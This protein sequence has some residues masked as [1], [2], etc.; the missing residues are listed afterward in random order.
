MVVLA[1][2]VVAAALLGRLCYIGRPFD[3]DAAVFIYM[4]KLIGDGGR[5]CHDLIDNKFPTVGLLTGV[6]W[7]AFGRNWWMYVALQTVMS[8]TAAGVLADIARRHFGRT[9]GG[10]DRVLPTL[11][12]AL[13]YLN[14]SPVVFGGFQLET[15]QLFFAVL[16]AH[17]AMQALHR[18][19][20]ADAFVVGLCAGCGAMAK[21]TALAVGAAF[22]LVT[23][24]ARWREWRRVSLHGVASL[25]GLAVPAL[26][27][28][29]YLLA[30]DTLRD[31]PG[32]SRQLSTYASNSV[33]AAE[34][35]IKPAIVAGLLGFPMIVYAWMTRPRLAPSA[36]TRGEG[37]ADLSRVA[38]WFVF[39]WFV[40]ECVG[41]VAQRRMYAYHFLPIAAPAALLFGMIPRRA[42]VAALT[43]ALLPAI[44]MSASGA[45][46]VIEFRNKTTRLPVGDYLREHAS[47]DAV[48]WQDYTARLLLENDFRPGSRVTLTFLF[49]NS[50]AAPLEYGR[51]IL[52]DFAERKPEYVILPADLEKFLNHQ[53]GQVAELARSPLRYQNYCRAWRSIEA[54]ARQHYQVETELDGHVIYRRRTDEITS[55][56]P[57]LSASTGSPSPDP[58]GVA[59]SAASCPRTP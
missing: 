12:F 18:D 3:Y 10:R 33:W 23:I 49:V 56:T 43:I 5:L 26:V 20:L 16:G 55:P 25:A 58:G 11:L 1:L 44:A 30:S 27:V 48:V 21:P 29:A 36:G 28:L 17:A 52:A 13:V 46:S 35:F 41:V 34:D 22:A 19:N 53:H 7:R 40:I 15:I 57:S 2:L 47:P 9:Q 54:Y 8:L 32:L 24:L 42:S 14:F 59:A 31:M 50:D 6:A 38:L 4:G 37:T 39:A 51:Q 45:S